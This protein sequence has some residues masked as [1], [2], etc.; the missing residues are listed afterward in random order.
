MGGNLIYV[1][2]LIDAGYAVS[3]ESARCTISK[4]RNTSISNRKGNLYYLLAEIPKA[5]SYQGLRTN[6]SVPEAI[7]V[8]YKR[9]GHRTLDQAAIQY[10]KLRVT[11]FKID[12]EKE[13]GS[14]ST[15]CETCASGRQHKE[16]MTGSREKPCELLAVV[17]SDISGPMQVSTIS[18]ERHCITFI[19]EMSGRIAVSLLKMQ[20]EWLGAFQGYKAGGEKEAAH[21]IKRVRT[22]GV[23]EYVRQAFSSYMLINGIVTFL[24]WLSYFI[25]FF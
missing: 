19:D 9:L 4:G 23:G 3:F 20:S 1:S 2:Q 8:W 7:E 15:I 6:K 12:N 22:D 17:H 11:D 13:A 25:A 21:E 5:I 18:G 14:A 24:F 10:L 16:S